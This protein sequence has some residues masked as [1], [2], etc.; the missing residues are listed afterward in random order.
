MSKPFPASSSKKSQNVWITKINMQ[1]PKTLK[2]RV[3]YSVIIYRS[4]I[5]KYNN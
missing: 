1:I 5:F 3:K 2:R 4:K